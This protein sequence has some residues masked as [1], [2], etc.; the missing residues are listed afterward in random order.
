MNSFWT[1]PAASMYFGNGG[2]IF[3]P[4][5]SIEATYVRTSS[6]ALVSLRRFAPILVVSSISLNGHSLH[7][8]V[9]E[10]PS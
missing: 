1:F 8:A 7:I 2:S 10:N 5:S 3:E 6:Y 9:Y 4:F